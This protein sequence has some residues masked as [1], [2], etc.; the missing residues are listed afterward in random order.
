MTMTIVD[1]RAEATAEAA[2]LTRARAMCREGDERARV[3]LENDATWICVSR[4]RRLRRALGGRVCLV[5]RAAFEDASGRLVESKLVPVLVDAGWQAFE[6]AI[7]ARVED[8]CERWACEV[9]RVTAAFTSARLAR[10]NEIAATSRESHAVSQPG[11][12]DRR[13]GRMHEMKAA[14]LA[15]SDQA[16]LERRRIIA[17]SGAIARVPARLLLVIVP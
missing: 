5:W 1:L 16:S 11:L 15:D 2:R 4:R 9:V 6:P 10:E 12:F 3:T 17:N 13:A 14:A 7:R 8:E